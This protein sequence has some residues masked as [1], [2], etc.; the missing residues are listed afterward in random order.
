M[1]QLVNLIAAATL[2]VAAVSSHAAPDP[3]P[4]KSFVAGSLDVSGVKKTM[5]VYAEYNG[6]EELTTAL[7]QRIEELGYPMA[8]SAESADIV[9]RVTPAYLGKAS[10]RPKAGAYDGKSMRQGVNI[11]Q[12]ILMAA[13][14]SAIGLE[15]NAANIRYNPRVLAA[16]WT[17]A[18]RDSGLTGT[19]SHAFKPTKKPQEAIVSH[20][21]LTVNGVL[22]QAD[23]VSETY[24]KDVPNEM[25]VAQN[26]QQAVWYL[27]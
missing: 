14:G 12:L 8:E 17:G 6:T 26:L 16:Y 1:K 10:D 21:E 18:S 23:V 4:V 11:G 19:V 27:E 3:T 5:T 25:L 22:Q 2:V 15:P 13:M 20:V 24:A 9:F 7:R